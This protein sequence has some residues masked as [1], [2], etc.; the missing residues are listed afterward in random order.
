MSTESVF[1]KAI[2]EKREEVDKENKED[3]K[4]PKAGAA[5]AMG[6]MAL[7]DAI[8]GASGKS[9]NFLSEYLKNKR[10]KKQAKG[11][12]FSEL[13]QL[14]KLRRKDSELLKTKALL[15]PQSKESI[16][17]HSRKSKLP[18]FKLAAQKYKK[19][20]GADLNTLA[21]AEASQYFKNY[22]DDKKQG[23]KE[24]RETK[25]EALRTERDDKKSKERIE[26]EDRK[27]K[28]RI[29]A[30]NRKNAERFRN[31]VKKNRSDSWLK[32]REDMQRSLFESVFDQL[33]GKIHGDF[34]LDNLE[35]VGD[36]AF[37]VKKYRDKD[38]V[39]KEYRQEIEMPIRSGFDFTK[40]LTRQAY[41]VFGLEEKPGLI[42]FE[43]S[44][45]NLLNVTLKDRSGAAVT[46]P[47]LERLK[48]ELGINK[49]FISPGEIL[50]ALKGLDREYKRLTDANDREYKTLVGGDPDLMKKWNDAGF[51]AKD[52]YRSFNPESSNDYYTILERAAKRVGSVK[53][54]DKIINFDKSFKILK[55]DKKENLRFKLFNKTFG[56]RLGPG[57]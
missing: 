44:M 40:A 28:E 45:A 34:S 49:G 27:E 12:T 24:K 38:G 31:N 56:S 8:S 6:F 55:R 17:W 57:K 53:V 33:K 9:T 46:V 23:I 32:T 26:R 41:K 30:E 14:E 10:A 36:K 39:L 2:R 15:D 16:D 50:G 20:T 54:G 7:G 1:K 47:E 18:A 22:L 29:K 37:Y 51:S 52:R 3:E 48:G 25:K 4:L 42:S 43:Q 19:E 35:A 5:M 13:I 11:P 21:P